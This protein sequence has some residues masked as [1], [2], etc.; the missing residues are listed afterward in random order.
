[1]SLATRLRRRYV[2]IEGLLT[3]PTFEDH[4]PTGIDR[5]SA[6]RIFE[7]ARLRPGLAHGVMPTEQELFSL[8]R[9]ELERSSNDDHDAPP[10]RLLK[11]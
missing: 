9:I 7:T 1:M 8:L 5:V 4:H 3:L 11:C 6:E 2:R 10:N